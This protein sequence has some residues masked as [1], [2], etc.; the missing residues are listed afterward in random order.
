MD[1]G[2]T[3][4]VVPRVGSPTSWVDDLS[5]PIPSNFARLQIIPAQIISSSF[6]QLTQEKAR[7]HIIL[8]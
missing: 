6:A 7:E 3:A 1:L 5:L 8:E 2:L 4:L